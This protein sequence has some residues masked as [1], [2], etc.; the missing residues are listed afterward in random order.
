MDFSKF[1]ETEQKYNDLK[2]KLSSGEINTEYMKKELKKMMVLDENGNYWMIGGKTG[3]WYIYNGTEWKESD[4]FAESTRSTHTPTQESNYLKNS[5]SEPAQDSPVDNKVG[6]TIAGTSGAGTV[7]FNADKPVYENKMTNEKVAIGDNENIKQDEYQYE[8]EE[9]FSLGSGTLKMETGNSS[10]SIG[11]DENEK[12]PGMDDEQE[13]QEPIDQYTICKIC[14]AKISIYSIYCPVCGANR[15]ESTEMPGKRSRSMVKEN[16]LLLASVKISSLI[17]FMGGLGLIAGVLWGA[18]FG[19]FKNFIPEFQPLL[20]DMLA[21]TRGGMA[22][23]LIFAAV[24]G[25]AAFTFSA[26]TAAF[27]GIVYNII[28]FIFGGIRFRIK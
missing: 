21:E 16:E 26:F 18:A 9:P 8:D 20:P 25:I 17:F 14:K 24:G 10:I 12:L 19:I 13:P 1:K 5:Y 4:P 15:K 6:R 11:D 22:G 7:P 23:G 3:R 27:M 28:A 2:A